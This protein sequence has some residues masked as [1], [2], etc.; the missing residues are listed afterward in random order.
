[1][2]RAIYAKKSQLENGK[3][4]QNT[5]SQ[6]A[7]MTKQGGIQTACGEVFAHIA[8]NLP[9]KQIKI[10]KSGCDP[11]VFELLNAKNHEKHWQPHIFHSVA[12]GNALIGSLKVDDR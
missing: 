1:M 5:I 7:E 4:V 8:I 9:R 6:E 3:C 10:P 12:Q 2:A 11:N